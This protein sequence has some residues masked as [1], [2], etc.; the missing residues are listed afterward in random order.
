MGPEGLLEKIK[1]DLGLIGL[2]SLTNSYAPVF[3]ALWISSGNCTIWVPN[4]VPRES[5]IHGD[6]RNVAGLARAAGTYRDVC[7]S[8]GYCFADTLTLF[9]SR[10]G[11]W[12]WGGGNDWSNGCHALPVFWKPVNPIST[13]W[14]NIP[15]IFFVTSDFQNATALEPST[16]PC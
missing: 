3:Y 4:T 6:N 15:T 7:V 1:Y 5:F 14:H 12:W 8:G 2:T 10:S 9:Q 13:G 16:W 11:W